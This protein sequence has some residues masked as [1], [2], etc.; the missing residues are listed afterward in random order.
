VRKKIKVP[1]TD[2]LSFYKTI[3]DE[4]DAIKN[5]VRNLIGRKHWEEEGRYKEAI[6]RNV[7]RRF[8]PSNFS[9]GTGFVLANYWTESPITSQIDIIVYDNTFP[10]LFHEGDFVVLTPQPVRAIIEVKTTVKSISDFETIAKKIMRNA[11]MIRNNQGKESVVNSRRIQEEKPQELF[12]G[13]FSYDC[14]NKPLSYLKRLETIFSEELKRIERDLLASC[15]I[16]N[17]CLSKTIY[18]QYKKQS[19]RNITLTAYRMENL[20]QGYFITSL[21]RS[22]NFLSI[23]ANYGAWIPFNEDDFEEETIDLL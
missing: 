10:T 14:N 17:I 8:L 2:L 5:R 1:E 23:Y 16:N 13:L 6:L 22:L 9:I 19:D 15:L 21:L 18:L 4:L 3:A 20:A 11:L 7:I 12:I